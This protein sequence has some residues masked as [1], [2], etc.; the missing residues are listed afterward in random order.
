VFEQ[1]VKLAPSSPNVIYTRA[2][3]LVQQKRNLGEAKTLLEKYLN[4]QLTPDDPPRE[5]AVELLK[6]ARG[7]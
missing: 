5:K 7:V 4:S 3:M 2:E 6:Q 1:A